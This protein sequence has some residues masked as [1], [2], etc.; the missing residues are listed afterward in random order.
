MEEKLPDLLHKH[1]SEKEL[2]SEHHVIEHHVH[3]VLHQ[4]HE[5]SEEKKRLDYSKLRNEREKATFTMMMKMNPLALTAIR[6]EFYAREDSIDLQTFIY[7]IQKHL[8]GG[9]SH[10][11]KFETKEQREFGTN[12]YE[13]FKDIDVNGD[14]DLEWQEFTSFVV[15]KANIINKRIKLASIPQYHDVTA[16]LDPTAYMRHQKIAKLADIPTLGQFCMIEE[17]RNAFFMFNSRSGKHFKTVPLDASPIAIEHVAEEGE[18][19]ASSFSNMTIATYSL[20]DPNL[21]RRYAQVNSWSTPGV[22]M[23]ITYLKDSK[24]LYSGSTNGNVYAWKI[25]DRELMSTFSGHSDII[26]SL[27]GLKKLNNIAS[28][29]LDKSI[30]VWDSYT[31]A[32]ILK[33][34]GHK[35]GILDLSYSPQYRLLFSCGFEHDACVWSPLGKNLV[36]KLKGHHA[37]LTGVVAVE[38][39]PEIITGDITGVFKLWDI[40]NFSCV[41][42]FKRNDVEAGSSGLTRFFHTKLPPRNS[43]QKEDDYRIYAAKNN[44]YAFDQT[45]VVHG[46]TTDYSNVFWMEWNRNSC[47]FIT[48]SENNLIVWDALIGS[49]TFTHSN[50]ITTEISAACLDDRKRKVILGDV[51]GCIGVYNYS[52]GALMKTVYNEDNPYTVI[53][54]EYVDETKRFI[55]GFENGVIRIYDENALED[56]NVLRTFDAFNMHPELIGLSF[57]PIDLTVATTGAMCT[58][59]RM[60]DY[61]AGKCEI[62]L[63][64]SDEDQ[65]VVHVVYLHPYPIVATSDSKGNI[66]LWLSRKSFKPGARITGWM[67]QTPVSAQLEPLLKLH[68]DDEE[69][70]PRR[71]LPTSDPVQIAFSD[72]EE[73]D[74][75]S[76]DFDT[77]EKDDVNASFDDDGEWTLEDA[78]NSIALAVQEVKDAQA[79]WGPVTPANSIVWNPD[80]YQLFTGDDLGYLR[81]FNLKNAINDIGGKKLLQ[82]NGEK[83]KV[84]YKCQ[85]QIRGF[86]AACPAVFDKPTRYLLNKHKNAM[87]YLGVDFLWTIQAH[88]DRIITCRCTEHGIL[89]SAA[90]MLVK[91]WTFEGSPVGVLLQNV[92]V[93]VP[94][95]HWK[96]AIDV[97]TIRENEEQELDEIIENVGEIVEDPDKPDI[98]N[99]DFLGME[100]GVNAAEF[101]YSELRQRIEETSKKLGIDF[102]ID[103]GETVKLEEESSIDF[104]SIASGSK[105]QSAALHEIKSPEGAV[106]YNAKFNKLTGL[107]QKQKLQKKYDIVK[108]YEQKA[109]MRVADDGE[110]G[111]G[112]L[113][114]EE[115]LGNLNEILSLSSEVEDRRQKDAMVNAD[116]YSFATVS[117]TL[118]KSNKKKTKGGQLQSTKLEASGIRAETLKRTCKKFESYDKLEAAMRRDLSKP[119]D[120]EV[121]A[122]TKALQEEK[123]KKKLVVS[124]YDDVIPLKQSNS[125]RSS[126][127]AE[128]KHHEPDD[129]IQHEPDEVN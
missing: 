28:G 119:V 12:M 90:D 84:H 16:A 110:K 116:M 121:I 102:P 34:L 89:T 42:T 24:L 50:I 85:L 100:P 15:E 23:A 22:Q 125:V 67:N 3:D 20:N 55:A 60:W 107:Q 65:V 45:R 48:A 56:C 128:E 40:R 75:V 80:T 17:S 81:S 123:R 44:I 58:V 72:D 8:M 9:A 97:D 66:M 105:S 95:R 112:S 78:Q 101:T 26:M 14:G 53:A 46:A 113:I 106:D 104:G 109:G 5:H 54:L 4:L 61:L 88:D 38:D 64:V 49:K 29:S 6:K 11:Y 68:N 2:Q 39:T 91:M 114:P 41:H 86:S 122:K 57:N 32:Q 118:P 98:E 74:D 69:E 21:N 87:A 71:I 1:I 124:V 94:A 117:M 96:L 83:S 70:P 62:E 103:K 25:Q 30:C 18:I 129:D 19:L 126:T 63:K 76:V 33:L 10:H 82:D 59:V 35:K 52:N 51:H 120:K 99:M 47:Q 73:D 127:F 108:L 93:G 111:G 13:L 37:S 79:K 31:N 36:Y 92:P 27:V 43:F 115:E 7:I 77:K